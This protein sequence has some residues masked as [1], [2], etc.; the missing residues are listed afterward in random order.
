MAAND[1]FGPFG[2]PES[3]GLTFTAPLP[4]GSDEGR[5]FS[6]SNRVDNRIMA[7]GMVMGN[8]SCQTETQCIY[9]I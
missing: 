1:C 3:S 2:I 5:C 8:L 6:D 7:V 9:S 4:Y